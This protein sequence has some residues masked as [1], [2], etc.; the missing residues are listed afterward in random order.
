[1]NQEIIKLTH[2]VLKIMREH[3]NQEGF[4]EVVTPRVV[5]ASGACENVNTLFEAGVD[6]NNHWFKNKKGYLAQT[7]QLYLEALVP[8][9]EKVYCI[10]PSFRAESKVDNRHLTEFLMLE[11]E[12][13]GG[14]EE[15]LK[16]IEGTL[17]AIAKGMIES[18]NYQEIGLEKSDLDRL[19]SC[20]QPFP[21]LSYDEAIKTLQKKGEKIEWGDDISSAQEKLLL[22]DYNN[23]PLFITHFPDP[24]CDFGKPIEAEKFFNML[25]DHKNP[26]RVLSC[27]LITPFGGESV[28]AAARVHRPKEIK[29]RLVNSRMFKRLEKLGGDLDDFSWYLDQA[30][31]NGTVPHSGCGFGIARLMQWVAGKES[32]KDVVAFP[33]DRA[34]II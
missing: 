29:R 25:P 31:T 12:H 23:C 30:E 24:M 26:G 18:G 15:L 33:T 22:R 32:I 5:R 27:D 19:K 21:R 17:Q 3:F 10:G 2:L 6:G 1:M 28:G 8:D 34:T 13:A 14:F 7:G 11:I 4:T 9:L 16:N 20:L